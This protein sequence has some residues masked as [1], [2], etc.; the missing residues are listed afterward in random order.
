MLI[1]D[2]FRMKTQELKNRT[3]AFALRVMNLVEALPKSIKGRAIANQLIRSGT[4]VAAN[5]R[6]ACR[7]RSKA[8]FISK[9]GTVEEEADESAL[10]MELI[11]EDKLLPEK[12]VRSLYREASELV[13]IMA[14]SCIWASRNKAISARSAIS[15]QKSEIRS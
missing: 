5:Y 6:A 3:K 1:S 9:I 8:E 4:S 10:W 13:A 14:A 11:I 12:K 7:A 15:N 2:C